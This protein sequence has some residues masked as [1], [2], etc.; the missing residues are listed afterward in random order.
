MILIS[1]A[2]FAENTLCVG[3]ARVGSPQQKICVSPLSEMSRTD[4]G[5][6]LHSLIIVGQLQPL[7]SEY[8]SQFFSKSCSLPDHD[9]TSIC[10][11]KC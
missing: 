10:D 9:L 3:L 7:E 4:L 11:D 8:L 1:I 2:A 5:P 6:P